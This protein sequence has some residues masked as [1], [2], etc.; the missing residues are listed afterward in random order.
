MYAKM[1]L[2]GVYLCLWFHTVACFLAFLVKQK[3]E[4]I[5]TLEFMFYGNKDWLIWNRKD[6]SDM[7]FYKVMLYHSAL[8]FSLVDIS[9]RTVIEIAFCTFLM[10][11]SAMINA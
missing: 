4:W 11:A 1:V 8:T 10:L 9:P 3:Q 2:V 6:V 7:E 5:P